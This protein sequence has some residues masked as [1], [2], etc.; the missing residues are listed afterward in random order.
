MNSQVIAAILRTDDLWIILKSNSRAI[1]D[2][3]EES[4]REFH[5]FMGSS[6][7]AK[8]VVIQA[9]GH[10]V[11]KCHSKDSVWSCLS[12]ESCLSTAQCHCYFHIT[13][14]IQMEFFKQAWTRLGRSEMIWGISGD[15]PT[16]FSSLFRIG[17]GMKSEWR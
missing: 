17:G 2:G 8:S 12:T 13:I 10:A 15:D 1:S 3:F 9:L 16:Y 11:F 6:F 14:A 7:D 5:F 4:A